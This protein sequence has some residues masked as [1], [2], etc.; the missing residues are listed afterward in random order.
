MLP[1]NR[2]L[3]KTDFDLIKKIK[4]KSYSSYSLNLRLCNIDAGAGPSKFAVI[5]P[6]SVSKRSVLR[7]K[8]KR[9]V[10]SIILKNLDHIKNGL[11]V[12]IYLKKDSLNCS[13]QELEEELLEVFNKSK[14][15][16]N[17]R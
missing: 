5:V 11:A 6:N 4:K 16:K 13:F 3:K 7:N 9:R 8:L 15:F 1:Q 2:R 10:K 12:L 14:I 17:A